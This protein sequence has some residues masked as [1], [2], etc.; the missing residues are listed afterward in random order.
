MLCSK[1]YA[2]EGN[3]SK[4][5]TIAMIMPCFIICLD[6]MHGTLSWCIVLVW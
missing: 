3:L 1:K 4:Q 5:T 2:N 6:K